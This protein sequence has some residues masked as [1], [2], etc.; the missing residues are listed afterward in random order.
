[1]PSSLEPLRNDDVNACA[2]RVQRFGGC[3]YLVD[4]RRAHSLGSCR[5]SGRIVSAE[6]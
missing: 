2:G 6:E 3:R 1:M 4:R 5:S